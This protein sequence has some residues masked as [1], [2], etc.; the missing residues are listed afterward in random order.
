MHRSFSSGDVED[1]FAAREM[2]NAWASYAKGN[3]GETYVCDSDT[4]PE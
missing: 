4:G 1:Y 2:Y 3:A